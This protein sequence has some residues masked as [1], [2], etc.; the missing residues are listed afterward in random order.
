MPFLKGRVDHFVLITST[1]GYDLQFSLALSQ[2]SGFGS[3]QTMWQPSCAKAIVA[4]PG[5]LPIS[6][7]L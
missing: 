5:P 3:M 1:D 4:V 2:K 7:L 6:R